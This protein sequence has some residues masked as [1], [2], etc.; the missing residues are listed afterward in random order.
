[1]SVPKPDT[2]SRPRRLSARQRERRQRITSATYALLAQHGYDALSMK[3]IAEAAGV[4]ERTLFNIYSS[5]DALIATS[6]HERAK[7]IIEEAWN[8]A[9][10]EGIGFFLSLSETLARITIEE[11]EVARALAPVLINHADLVGLNEIYR[12]YVGR[13]LAALVDQDALDEEDVEVLTSLFTMRMVSAVNLWAS[14]TIADDNLEVHMRLAVC[15]VLLPH[16]RGALAEWAQQE[17]RRCLS[18][19]TGRE[20]KFQT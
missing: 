19:L 10:D 6:T 3:M 11:P 16:V 12:R 14:H 7:G 13:A 5:K 18:M 1:M 20:H 15:Q 4:A 17:A 9:S 8:L 2:D